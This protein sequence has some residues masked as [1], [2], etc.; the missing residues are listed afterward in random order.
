MTTWSQTAESREPR[1]QLLLSIFQCNPRTDA[2]ASGKNSGST[3][4]NF[5]L[6]GVPGLHGRTVLR[7]TDA[8]RDPVRHPRPGRAGRRGP[9]PR[10]VD[11]GAE[12]LIHC[13]DLTGPDVVYECAGCPA[14]SSSATTTIDEKGLRERWPGRRESASG[15]AGRSR[16]QTADRR[17]PRRLRPARSDG[18]PAGPDYLLFGHSHAG[19]RREGP[20]PLDQP[21]RPAPRASLDGRPA[22]PG[23]RL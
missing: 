3:S 22:R 9:S 12:A 17:D 14:I 8:D 18:S 16:W 2:M 7:R 4:A 10:L 19:R 13:G 1:S 6:P 21:G 20:D 11:E 15:V 23:H 5:V